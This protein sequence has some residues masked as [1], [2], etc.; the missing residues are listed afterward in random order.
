[1]DYLDRQSRDKF[2][3]E[4]LLH[5]SISVDEA[6]EI[7]NRYFE[8]LRAEEEEEERIRAQREAELA[9]KAAERK[10]KRK[11]A[12]FTWSFPYCLDVLSTLGL[13]FAGLAYGYYFLGSHNPLSMRVVGVLSCIMAVV[14]MV[15][16]NTRLATLQQKLAT[17]Q[18]KS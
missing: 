1:M 18:Q 3:K 9:Q 10:E 14:L 11:S 2:A 16:L 6:L 4:L 17:L 15:R 8:R 13:P 7:S 5:R 12:R